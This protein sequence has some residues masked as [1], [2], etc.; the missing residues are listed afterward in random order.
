MVE[1]TGNS[2]RLS[3]ITKPMHR[4]YFGETRDVGD[5]LPGGQTLYF[6]HY[7]WTAKVARGIVAFYLR[8]WKWVWTTLIS[9]AANLALQGGEG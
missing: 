7:H 4:W 2:M 5:P 1:W 8:N 6:Q 3:A 9:C